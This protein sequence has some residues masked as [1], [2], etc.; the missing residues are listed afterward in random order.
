[1]K[2]LLINKFHYL[3]GGAERY[4]FEWEKLLRARGHEVMLHCMTHPKNRPCPQDRFFVRQVTFDAGQS[5]R[6]KARAALHAV[7]CREA[8]ARL[9]ALLEAEGSPDIAHLHSF[10]FQLT[11]SILRPLIERRIPI[12]QTC[13]EYSPVCVNQRLFNQRTNRICE[14]CLKSTTLSPLWKRCI[15]GSFAASAVGWAAGLAARWPAGNRKHI[16]RFFTP[17]SFMREKLIEGG[18]PSGR[19]AVVPHFIEAEAISPSDSAGDYMLFFGRLVPQKGVLTFLRAA[20]QCPGIPC[21]ILGDGPLTEI[22]RSRI[23]ERGLSNVQPLGRLEGEPLWNALRAARAVVVPSEWYEP[24]GL[25]ILEGM[26]AGR[27]VIASRVAGPAEIVEHERDGLLFE[28]GD[29]A[30]L[31]NAMRRLWNDPSTARELGRHGRAKALERFSPA[32]HYDIMIKHF[33][34]VAR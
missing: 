4:L 5:T 22:V 29:A 17:S 27:P 28:M 6:Q 33:R 18:L 26:A 16:R 10:M 32:S 31:A 34:D 1:V 21:K 3:S 19:V 23:A 30:A 14:A 9:R 11:P 15:K 25:V 2:I 12:V 13:H 7:W 8:S 20:E 24:F